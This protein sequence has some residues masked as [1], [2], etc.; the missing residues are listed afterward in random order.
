M[1]VGQ[2]VPQTYSC[3]M[4]T[5]RRGWRDLVGLVFFV[6]SGMSV[7]CQSSAR[8][9]AADYLLDLSHFLGIFLL[10]AS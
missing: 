8:L 2:L 4:V 7:S 1:V 6:G 5:V 3:V 9:R 10:S